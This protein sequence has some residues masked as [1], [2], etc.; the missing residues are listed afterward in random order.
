MPSN[1][2]IHLYLALYFLMELIS[3]AIFNAHVSCFHYISLTHYRNIL[4]SII[5]VSK[6]Q[7]AV[8]CVLL[9]ALVLITFLFYNVLF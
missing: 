5:K 7:L 3:N 4:V 9:S 6:P 2:F 8:V 1:S